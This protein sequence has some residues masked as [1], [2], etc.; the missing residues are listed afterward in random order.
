M[1]FCMLWVFLQTGIN[2]SS[3][4]FFPPADRSNCTA[5]IFM[6][7]K[8]LL[9]YFS[10]LGVRKI[11]S[12]NYLYIKITYWIN[13]VLEVPCSGHIF[14]R[15]IFVDFWV[16]FCGYMLTKVKTF[17][18]WVVVKCL[19]IERASECHRSSAVNFLASKA[20]I[21]NWNILKLLW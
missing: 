4:L 6:K 2:V 5:F 8:H 18:I 13:V 14:D 9:F 19:L 16:E 11:D 7:E 1:V 20:A 21:F 17:E 3:K 15:S 10:R 12:M